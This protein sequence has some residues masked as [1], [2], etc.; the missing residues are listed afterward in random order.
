[1]VPV[2]AVEV[3]P[4]QT[5][6]LAPGGMH[7]MFMGLGAPLTEGEKIDAELVFEKAGRVEVQF[8]VEPRAETPGTD[9]AGH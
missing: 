1:M 5:V 6:T 3:P 4:G 8:N 7:V 2:E 9:H